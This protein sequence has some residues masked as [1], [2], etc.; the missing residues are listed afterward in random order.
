MG[1]L[2]YGQKRSYLDARKGFELFEKM[3]K[4]L[5]ACADADDGRCRDWKA[6]CYS[7]LH[8][9]QWHCPRCRGIRYEYLDPF[10]HIHLLQHFRLLRSTS[11]SYEHRRD[12]HGDDVDNK[13]CSPV[14]HNFAMSDL[15][16]VLWPSLKHLDERFVGIFDGMPGI[17]DIMIADTSVR[18]RSLIDDS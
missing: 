12:Q 4:R 6:E 8:R 10:L 7:R 3:K 5:N 14:W 17:C 1:S 9:R 15:F 13:R 18:R 16:T 2:F 11:S